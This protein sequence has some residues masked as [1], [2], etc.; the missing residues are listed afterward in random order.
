MRNATLLVP[1]LA[2]KLLNLH[3]LSPKNVLFTIIKAIQKIEQTL[4]DDAPLHTQEPEK[5]EIQEAQGS[6]EE[7][8]TLIRED[9]KLE[10]SDAILSLWK[11][12]IDPRNV[13]AIRSIPTNDDQRVHH[14]IHH[15]HCNNKPNTENS[16]ETFPSAMNFNTSFT[17]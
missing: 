14:H 13:Q 12:A 8:R 15:S 7:H 11:M 16:T 10:F 1:I 3:D 9:I 2:E 17:T 6:L 5:E 4:T